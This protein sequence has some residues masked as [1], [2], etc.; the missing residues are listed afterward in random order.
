MTFLDSSLLVRRYAGRRG[1]PAAATRDLLQD[2]AVSDIARVEVPSALQRRV[3]E[4][5]LDPRGAKAALDAFA[6]DLRSL[7]RV[8]VDDRVLDGSAALLKRH[9]LRSL[10]AIQLASALRLAHGAPGPV[11]FGSADARLNAAARAEG[12]ELLLP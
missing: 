8:G 5:Q 4:G 2:F 3:R 1:A 12:L 7:T 11:T 10:D 9:P 6:R